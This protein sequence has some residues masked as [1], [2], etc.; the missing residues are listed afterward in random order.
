[1]TV[2]N[3]TN[4]MLRDAEKAYHQLVTGTQ[5]RVVVDQNGERVEFTAAN[6]TVLYQYIMQLKSTLG[7]GCGNAPSL[8][9]TYGPAQF[10]F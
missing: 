2:I 7:S 4:T 8:P 6:K 1:M 5:P 9:Q 10:F 3:A